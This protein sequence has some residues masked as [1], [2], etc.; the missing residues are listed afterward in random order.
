M[1]TEN[2]HDVNFVVD[3]DTRRCSSDNPRCN[4]WQQS[5]ATKTLGSHYSTLANVIVE[6]PLTWAAGQVNMTVLCCVLF[7]VFRKCFLNSRSLV[8]YPQSVYNSL[9]FCILK[10]KMSEIPHGSRHR[11]GINTLRPKLNGWPITCD[12]FKGIFLNENIS[13]SF[14]F[15]WSLFLRVKLTIQHWFR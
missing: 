8:T 4:Q 9:S 7:L 11:I 1:E 10:P 15:D 6:N 3:S 2:C 14:R 12:I 5:C 13:I